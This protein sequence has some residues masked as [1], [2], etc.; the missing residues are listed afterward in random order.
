MTDDIV[1]YL[2]L[3]RTRFNRNAEAADEIERL[4]KER[5]YFHEMCSTIANKNF[6]ANEEI[7]RL[8]K[9]CD[10]FA[11]A[12]EIQV[13]TNRVPVTTRAHYSQHAINALAAWGIKVSN[14]G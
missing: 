9:L 2:R 5:D 12:L 10:Q 3:S 7:E 1:R 13:Q 4:R 6:S 11:E 14:F 8:R